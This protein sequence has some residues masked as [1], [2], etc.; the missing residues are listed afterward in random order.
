MLGRRRVRLRREVVGEGALWAVWTDLK[1]RKGAAFTLTLDNRRKRVVVWVMDR[2][3][4]RGA[5][6]RPGEGSGL[7]PPFV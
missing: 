5:V 7:L 2:K 3:R 4:R 6:I 1:A